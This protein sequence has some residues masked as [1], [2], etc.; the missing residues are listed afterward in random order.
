MAHLLLPDFVRH[1]GGAPHRT[2]PAQSAEGKPHTV[3]C[4]ARSMR[5]AASG[6]M[7]GAPKE[8]SASHLGAP[9]ALPGR[10]AAWEPPAALLRPALRGECGEA[11][12]G[13][14]VG[15]ARGVAGGRAGPG[16]G[17]VL[18]VPAPPRR[19][20][21][22]G[23][24]AGGA[25]A[26]GARGRLRAAAQAAA[27]AG[28][29]PGRAGGLAGGGPRPAAPGGERRPRHLRPR[30]QSSGPASAPASA[31]CTPAAWQCH[32][33]R[34]SIRPAILSPVFEWMHTWALRAGIRR[35]AR[36]NAAVCARSS[37]L[38]EQPWQCRA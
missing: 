12:E 33:T 38:A 16:G 4:M 10:E 24:P 13:P 8:G 11:A 22:G 21:R 35:G 29:G 6:I 30:G 28:A 31:N 20:R 25:A 19:R 36:R 2:F 15:A 5:W 18:G 27:G 23:R 37:P 7:R 34:L 1:Q 3:T 32:W 14:V 9:G 26:A 17:A